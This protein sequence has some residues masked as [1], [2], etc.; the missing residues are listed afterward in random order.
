MKYNYEH[1]TIHVDKERKVFVLRVKDCV[2]KWKF[3]PANVARS[4]DA[5]VEDWRKRGYRYAEFGEEVKS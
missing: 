1:F 2:L 4:I 5:A 3:M